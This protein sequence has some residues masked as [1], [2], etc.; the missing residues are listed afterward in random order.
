MWSNSIRTV[1]F[2]ATLIEYLESRTLLTLHQAAETIG[3]KVLP[4]FH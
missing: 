4:A 3:S 2:A 1:V